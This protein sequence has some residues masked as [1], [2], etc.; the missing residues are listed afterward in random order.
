[1]HRTLVP[2]LATLL[3]GCDAE[4]GHIATEAPPAAQAPAPRSFQLDVSPLV[5]T[6]PVTIE[7]SGAQPFTTVYLFRAAA[8]TPFGFCP[9]AIAPDCLDLSGQPTIQT[10]LRTD[11]QGRATL[12]IPAFPNVNL[13]AVGL[14]AAYLNIGGQLDSSNPVLEQ[15][16]AADS[17]LDGDGLTAYEEVA[18]YGTLPQGGDTDGGGVDDGTE[19][20]AG[21]DPLDPS[22]DITDDFAIVLEGVGNGFIAG[23]TYT[24]TEVW[25]WRGNVTGDV[26]CQLEYDLVD[27]ASYPFQSGPSVQSG[28][29]G[30]DFYFTAV[31]HNRTE[32]TP[33]GLCAQSNVPFF[34]D[35]TDVYTVG[36]GFSSSNI[37]FDYLWGADLWAPSPDT[38]GT[39]DP[40]TGEW[41]Y[42]FNHHYP[43]TP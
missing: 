1:M 11:S 17:D 5:V 8:V 32:V 27:Q 38:T 26:F 3:L 16:Q 6:A 20:A 34:A 7:V 43:W 2:V 12:N 13:F 22:D 15:I 35:F 41:N 23:A 31:T 14:Q 30:C 33:P 18:I 9:S 21:L 19:V 36:M 39:F 25:T 29:V 40:V 42:V 37:F 24:G 28:C 4:Q 10:T